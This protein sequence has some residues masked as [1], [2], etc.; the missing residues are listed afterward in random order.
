M[1]ISRIDIEKLSDADLQSLV[2]EYRWWHTIQLR[3]N[4]ET[5]GAAKSKEYLANELMNSAMPPLKGLTVLDVGAWDGFYSFYAEQQGAARVVANDGF[6][7]AT[8]DWL[9][10]DEPPTPRL[11]EIDIPQ[12]RSVVEQPPSRH[13][14][15]RPDLMRGAIPFQIAHRALNS[16]VE[17]VYCAFEELPHY[18]FGAFDVVVFFGVLYHLEDPVASL[19]RLRKLTKGVVVVQTHAT[20]FAGFTTPVAEFFPGDELADD[21]SNWWSGNAA[22]V[23]GWFRA[24]GFSRTEVVSPVPTPATGIERYH[25]FVHAYA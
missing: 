25:L 12:I 8:N 9:R 2:D 17:P 21:V 14:R 4:V 22:C 5:R 19:K 7:W 16:K 24:A 11:V 6:I 15:Y 18:G 20:E 3:P 1:D 13:P 23:T 10:P